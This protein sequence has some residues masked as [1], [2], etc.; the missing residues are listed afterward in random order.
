MGQNTNET[1]N[2][3][4]LFSLYRD[5]VG[6]FKELEKRAYNKRTIEQGASDARGTIDYG[7]IGIIGK[8]FGHTIK[9]AIPFLIVYYIIMNVVNLNGESLLNHLEN[10]LEP[11]MEMIN[12]LYNI[13]FFHDGTLGQLVYALLGLVIY[14]GLFPCIFFLFPLMIICNV[15][16][17]AHKISE[18]KKTLKAC[19]ELLPQAEALLQEACKSIAPYV[20]KIPRDYRNS[21]ALAF[22]SNSFFNYKVRNLP[23]AVNLYDQYLHQQRMEQGQREMAKAQR[24][25]MEDISRQLDHME[26]LINS[27][28]YIIYETHYH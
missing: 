7:Y 24:D 11:M 26:D 18:A 10:L 14:G 12:G 27:Q 22:F 16:S 1:T 25:A 8:A 28:E 13:P 5:L 17:R 2:W 6:P 20:D 23:E 9:G 19:E 3:R 4:E 15:I 21:E